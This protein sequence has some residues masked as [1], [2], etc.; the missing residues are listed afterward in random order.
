MKA[1]EFVTAISLIAGLLCGSLFDVDAE[2]EKKKN[3]KRGPEKKVQFR[4]MNGAAEF[5][6]DPTL[7][8]LEAIHA[9]CRAT[10]GVGSAIELRMCGYTEGSRATLEARAGD[11]RVAVK[12]YAE[13]DN[14]TREAALYQALDASL[15]G[16]SNHTPALLGWNRELRVL[17]LG[18]L[19]GPTAEDLVKVGQGRRAG[20]L[21]ARWLQ[22]SASLP[23]KLG[24]L[25]GAARV[26]HQVDKWIAALGKTAPALAP[27]AAALGRT[28]ARTKL[29]EDAPR[30]VHSRLYARHVLDVGDGP[31]VIDW[32]RF[33]QGPVELD[34]GMFL[35]T[36]ARLGLL[37][38][39]RAAQ[40]QLAEAE[41]L[42]G[43]AGLVDPRSLAW[44]EA[45][46][47]LHLAERRCKQ[48]ARRGD[49]DGQTGA[50]ALLGEATRLVH[51]AG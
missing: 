4:R 39:S 43:I 41:F 3:G 13:D 20:E 50:R 27:S 44:H 21:G 22:R 45:A 7:P 11:H 26:L 8:A 25:Y 14:A 32:Q 23:I 34:A 33:G 2:E 18:W 40:A 6:D 30:L 47:L 51:A 19:N 29:H 28:L 12:A 24:P 17:I 5:P 35:A 42:A 38:E 31:G 16:D 49:D 9:A 10:N 37:N 1:P 46:A 48:T 15:A 36:I